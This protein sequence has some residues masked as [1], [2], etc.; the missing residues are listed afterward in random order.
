MTEITTLDG[1]ASSEAQ[2]YMSRL[3]LSNTLN[4]EKS[5]KISDAVKPIPS[6]G[7]IPKIP[8]AESG[9]STSSV[10]CTVSTGFQ[11]RPSWSVSGATNNNVTSNAASAPV[12]NG[13]QGALPRATNAGATPVLQGQAQATACGLPPGMP[14]GA[15]FYPVFQYPAD[16]FANPSILINTI[17]PLSGASGTSV[18]DFTRAV[19]NVSTLGQWNDVVI[20]SVAL[21]KLK[22]VALEFIQMGGRPDSWQTM[23]ARLHRRFGVLTT[24]LTAFTEFVGCQQKVNERV[25]EF[26]QRLNYLGTKGLPEYGNDGVQFRFFLN[27]LRPAVRSAV[28]QRS[29]VNYEQALEYALYYEATEANGGKQSRAYTVSQSSFHKGGNAENW[30]KDIVC[31]F[32]KRNGH[33]SRDCFQRRRHEFKYATAPSR[34]LS[35]TPGSAGSMGMR[36]SSMVTT[37]R[38][39]FASR[40]EYSRTPSPNPGCAPKTERI[41]TYPDGSNDDATRRRGKSPN[42]SVKERGRYVRN[43]DRAQQAKPK[44]N[45]PKVWGGCLSR[46]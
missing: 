19:D 33:V 9:S 24:D 26:A 20:V 1:A 46:R 17:E 11:F 36:P 23:K 31:H 2:D 5:A 43:E 22:G 10:A 38:V 39:R 41:E 27:G 3:S 4:L 18:E 15:Q 45:R 25:A 8:T 35:P 12:A 21:S 34:P 32:C 14:Y 37:R 44:E 29:P 40:P 16:P 13:A 6:L 42:G 30:Q 28:V 7:A